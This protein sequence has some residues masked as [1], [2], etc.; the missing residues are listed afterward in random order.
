MGCYPRFLTV[1]KLLAARAMARLSSWDLAPQSYCAWGCFRFFAKS[2]HQQHIHGHAE[3]LLARA[4]DDA[5]DRRDVGKV[6]R[7]RQDDVIV[8][9]QDIVGRIETDPADRVAAPYRHPGVGGVGALP[10]P[11]LAEGEGLAFPGALGWAAS[12]PGGRGG[13]IIRVTTLAGEGPG[14]PAIITWAKS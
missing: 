2:L 3:L 7:D 12:T 10:L 1:E 4:D 8:A 11:V 14:R 9:N 6:A 5:V 13:R